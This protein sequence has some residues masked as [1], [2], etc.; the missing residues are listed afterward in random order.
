MNA[1][2]IALEALE[3]PADEREVFLETQCAGDETLRAEVIRQLEEHSSADNFFETSTRPLE[4]FYGLAGAKPGDR[5]GPYELIEP[6]GEGGFGVVWKAR[7]T[8]PIERLVALKLIKPGM[9]TRE[10]LARFAAERQALARMEHPNIARVYDAGSTPTGRP[11][12]VMEMVEGIPITEFC[13]EHQLSIR[14]RIALVTW[15]CEAMGHAHQKGVIHRD[16]KP[17]NILVAGCNESVVKVIDFGVAK[18]FEGRLTDDTLFTIADQLVGTPYCMSPEQAGRN[19]AK[20]D[21]RT[22]IYGI[23]TLLYELLCG[24]PPFD[25][26]GK[27]ISE[28]RRIVC[29]VDPPRPSLRLQYLPAG[30]A[31]QIAANR[32]H[33]PKTLRKALRSELDWIAHKAMEKKPERRYQSTDDLVRDLIRYHENKPVTARP[34]SS[35]YIAAKFIRRNRTAITTTLVFSLLLAVSVLSTAWIM[36][37][38]V[39]SLFAPESQHL[40]NSETPPAS[41]SHAESQSPAQDWVGGR[42]FSEK[43]QLLLDAYD[44]GE[45]MDQLAARFQRAEGGVWPRLK[46]FFESEGKSG[47]QPPE[48]PESSANRSPRLRKLTDFIDKSEGAPLVEDNFDN[49]KDSWF[50][51]DSLQSNY[52]DGK[53]VLEGKDGRTWASRQLAFNGFACEVVARV[54]NGKHR[55]WG[56]LIYGPHHT[57]IREDNPHQGIEVLLDEAGN[58]RIIPDRWSGRQNSNR[59]EI[60]PMG[61]IQ[62]SNF[63][64][65]E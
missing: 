29:D 27:D 20:I 6:L 47:S 48:G 65:G 1:Q 43:E 7:Q 40:E 2:E 49:P 5:I 52:R 57:E 56:L 55:G 33:S 28:I 37:G 26:S 59:V 17:S 41:A 42:W 35:T 45:F 3:L 58:L 14:D 34:P 18:A 30:K 11:Y 9:D 8:E 31:F 62:V 39:G 63:K 44:P 61:P 51:R 53:L 21:A 16:I 64:P 25:F 22:D 46:G 13:D 4:E 19:G 23:G 10:V 24:L 50:F 38:T 54:S 60:A 12:F 15:V 32:N 36:R